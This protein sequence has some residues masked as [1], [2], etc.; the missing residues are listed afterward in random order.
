MTHPLEDELGYHFANASLL[1]Q[2]LTHPSARNEKDGDVDNQRMEYLGDA[3]LALAVAEFLYHRHGDFDEG[4]LTAN[5]SALTSSSALASVARRAGLG[6]HLILGRGE[7]ASGGRDKDSN[8]ADVLEALLGACYLDGGIPAAIAVFMTLFAPF[9]EAD[10]DMRSGTN[11]KGQL[12]EWAQ[13]HTLPC[14][15]YELLSAE[16]PSHE[17]VFLVRVSVHGH[18][19]EEAT[20]NSKKAAEAAAARKLLSRLQHV[21]G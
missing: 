4:A 20:G 10:S 9:I 3:V 2:A 18:D 7:E 1:E 14:P 17:P 21:N 8:L 13:R 5:R 12:Q 11:P 16:G 6:H 15:S 19:P